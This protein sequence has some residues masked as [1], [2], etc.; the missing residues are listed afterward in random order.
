MRTKSQE[1]TKRERKNLVSR[2]EKTEDTE[3]KRE[4]G[5]TRVSQKVYPFP[6]KKPLLR[7]FHLAKFIATSLRRKNDLRESVF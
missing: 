3:R 7:R 2:R 1:K 5:V 4:R 6:S